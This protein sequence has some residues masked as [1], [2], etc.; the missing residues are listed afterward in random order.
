MTVNAVIGSLQRVKFHRHLW[1]TEILTLL[2]LS[3]ALGVLYTYGIESTLL[4]TNPF[5]VYGH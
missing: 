1:Q 3:V 4:M 2:P 5:I